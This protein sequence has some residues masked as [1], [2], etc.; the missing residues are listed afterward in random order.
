MKVLLIRLSSIGDILLSAPLTEALADA[1]CEVHYVVK[2]SFVMVLSGF[3]GITKIHEVGED[4][5]ALRQELKAVQPDWIC[6]LQNNLKSRQITWGFSC[7]VKRLQKQNIR[8][9]ILVKTSFKNIY[10]NHIIERYLDTLPDGINRGKKLLNWA[11]P[12]QAIKESESFQDRMMDAK[13]IA[14]TMGSRQ[15]TKLM[16]ETLLAGVIEGMPGFR[17]L[18]LGGKEDASAANRLVNQFG[19][20]VLNV[21][22]KLSWPASVALMNRV[23]CVLC[24]DTGLMHAAAALGKPLVAVWGS[25][26]PALGMAPVYPFISDSGRASHLFLNLKCQPCSRIGFSQCPEGHFRCMLEMSP[27]RIISALL[28]QIRDF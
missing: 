15:K 3:R 12:I 17:F 7:P 8:K 27:D 24:N 22:G 13:W 10:I 9:H 19:V 28:S 2:S 21:C 5:H 16:P 1:G 23:S 20:Q 18:L 11:I 25:T 6:D 26:T 14:I 4:L